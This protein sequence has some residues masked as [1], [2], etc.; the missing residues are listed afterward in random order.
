M[1]PN[2]RPRRRG[3]EPEHTSTSHCAEAGVLKV[4]SG[5]E[6]DIFGWNGQQAGR[7]PATSVNG[8][9]LHPEFITEGEEAAVVAAIDNAVW[10]NELQRRVQHYGWRY[11]YQFRQIDPSMHL[12]RL[13]AW[14]GQIARRLVEAGHFRNDPPDQVI[15]NE[16]VANQGI[17]AHIDSPRSFTGVVATVSLL[18]SW[19]M[20]FRRRDPAA[21]VN[22]TLE[23][24]SVAILEGEVRYRWTHE[25]PKRHSE[26]GPVKPSNKRPSRIRRE[27][28]ISLT[29]RKVKA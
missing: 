17:S 29:F 13:P 15:V 26:P 27:R 18:E 14:A 5:T 2:E 24:R 11:D 1:F 10:S 22:R 28:R 21:K 19:E 9:T 8:L 20:V 4:V 23:R 12:G 25:I 6:H 7:E 3:R 16:Y